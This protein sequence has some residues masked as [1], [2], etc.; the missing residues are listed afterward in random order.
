MAMIAM[1]FAESLSSAV[2]PVG[3]FPVWGVKILAIS[4]TVMINSIN[5]LGTIGGARTANA[6]LVLKLLAIFSIAVTGIAVVMTGLH[7]HEPGSERFASDLDPHRQT[8][9]NWDKAGEYITAI[10]GALFCYRGW[11]SVSIINSYSH[12]VQN[13]C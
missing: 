5:C 10:Y 13:F 4:G 2:T 1:I 9:L 3:V 8:M 11:E 12:Q 6:L 7:S